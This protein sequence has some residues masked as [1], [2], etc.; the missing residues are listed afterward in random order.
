MAQLQPHS[1][2]RY[3]SLI[4]FCQNAQAQTLGF[5]I[6]DETHKAL[7]A[8]ALPRLA[9]GYI[10]VAMVGGAAASLLALWGFIPMF[11]ITPKAL[12]RMGCG[13]GCTGQHLDRSLAK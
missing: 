10:E 5:L 6:I 8:P 4:S 12:L 3:G 9:Q 7:S 11:R 2:N 13:T 1:F